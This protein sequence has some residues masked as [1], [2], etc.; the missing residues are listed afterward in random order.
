MVEWDPN[1]GK[2]EIEQVQGDPNQIP[3]QVI[4]SNF[5]T[6]YPVGQITTP[7]RQFTL[8]LKLNGTSSDNLELYRSDPDNFA[9]WEKM[10]YTRN[11]NALA[12]MTQTGGTYVVTGSTSAGQIAGIVIGVLAAVVL[13][14]GAVVYFKM[15]PDKLAG[16]TNNTV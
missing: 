16:L 12:V 10:E 11:G 15:H 2:W 13:V 6:V 9:T 7:D 8:Q 3:G 14:V 4:E 1:Q 5:V